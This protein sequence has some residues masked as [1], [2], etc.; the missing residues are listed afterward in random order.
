MN[1]VSNSIRDYEERKWRED[2]MTNELERFREIHI[3]L[4]Q[5]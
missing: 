5:S 2:L 1:I 4:K 3:H